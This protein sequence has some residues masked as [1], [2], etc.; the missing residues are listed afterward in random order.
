MSFLFFL[1]FVGWVLKKV[2]SADLIAQILLGVLYGAPVRNI[3]HSSWQENFLSVGY[4]TLVSSSS[5]SKEA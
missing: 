4:L 2:I 1:S 5:Y 3:L